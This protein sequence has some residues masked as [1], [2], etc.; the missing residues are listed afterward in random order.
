MEFLEMI[1]KLKQM[2]PNRMLL[3][4]CGAFYIATGEDAVTL[5]RKL[6][7]KV[8]CAKKY[9]CKVGVPKSSIEKYSTK[10]NELNYKYIVLDYEKEQNKII[11]KCIG[12]EKE[13]PIYGF[14][15]S[16]EQ[17]KNNKIEQTEYDIAFKK[18]IDEEF[19]DDIIW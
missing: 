18:Y 16:C 6:G 13:K 3:I 10:L 17:C 5:N 19:G 4:S 7:L 8:S 12:G 1:E 15:K 11:T 9:V 14:N 2:Y